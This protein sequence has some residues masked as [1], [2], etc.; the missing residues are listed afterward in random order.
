MRRCRR[1]SP[2]R[3]HDDRSLHCWRLECVAAGVTA[4]RAIGGYGRQALGLHRGGLAGHGG[5]WRGFRGGRHGGLRGVQ[6]S[7]A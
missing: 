4:P 3:S 6:T 2:W 7:M 1:R 5:L